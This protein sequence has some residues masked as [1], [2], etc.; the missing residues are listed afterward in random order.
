MLQLTE[1]EFD[2]VASGGNALN[3]GLFGISF[4]ALVSLGSVLATVDLVSAKTHAAFVAATIVF[5]MSSL[6]FG[7]RSVSE[8]LELKRRIQRYKQDSPAAPQ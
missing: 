6:L 5:G 3:V 1:S 4:G 7:A 8:Y 2:E